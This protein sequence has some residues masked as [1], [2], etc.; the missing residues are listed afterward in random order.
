MNRS[1]A[2][3]A[4]QTP[5]TST[6]L[7]ASGESIGSLQN[8]FATSSTIRNDRGTKLMKKKTSMIKLVRLLVLRTL[9]SKNN[10]CYDGLKVSKIRKI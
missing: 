9:I 7:S 1:V 8:P 2:G 4:P 6:D 10:F 5:S 3:L